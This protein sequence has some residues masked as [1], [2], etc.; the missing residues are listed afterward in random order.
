MIEVILTGLT[1]VLARA[2][3]EDP[4]AALVAGRTLWEDH[5]DHYAGRL[6]LAFIVDGSL[7]C[8]GVTLD[9]VGRSLA[10][11]A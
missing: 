2:E 11:T 9:D 10:V 6:S 8:D 3:A 7:L 4:E 1:G 5:Q